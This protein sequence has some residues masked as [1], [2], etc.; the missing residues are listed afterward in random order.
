MGEGSSDLIM[1][2]G[3]IIVRKCGFGGG[4]G[5][6]AGLLSRDKCKNGLAF[7]ISQPSQKRGGMG[8]PALVAGLMVGHLPDGFAFT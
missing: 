5:R 7:V 1:P 8:H 2:E 3:S 6:C 4:P